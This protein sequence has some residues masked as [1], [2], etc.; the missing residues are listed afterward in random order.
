MSWF[1]DLTPEIT[2]DG[3]DALLKEYDSRHTKL[4]DEYERLYD[5]TVEP[6]IPD[7]LGLKRQQ[8]KRDEWTPIPFLRLAVSKIAT[9][10]Y[11]R[12]VDRTTGDESLDKLLDP[13]WNMMKRF[14]PGVC[15]SG[16]IIGDGAIRMVPSWQTGITLMW[17][18]GRHIVPIYD[19]IT[20]EIVGMIYDYIYD[21]VGSQITR[22]LG[23][24]GKTKAI[25]EIV[26]R[27]VRDQITGEILQPGI[28]A[29]FD[30]DVRIPWDEGMDPEIDRLNPMGDYLDCVFWKNDD[31]LGSVRG[32][33]DAKSLRPLLNGINEIIVQMKLVVKYSAYPIITTDAD[34][35]GNPQVFAGKV[36]ALGET[37]SGNPATAQYLEWSQKMDGSLKLLDRLIGLLHET[38]QVPAVAVGDLEHI[39][40]LSSG[41][42]YEVA[43]SPVLDL[44]SMRQQVYTFQELE[45]MGLCVAGLA[46]VG[47]A[48][49]LTKAQFGIDNMPDFERIEE[50]LAEAS[51]EFAPVNVARDEEADARTHSTRISAGFESEEQAIRATHPD[52]SDD[53]VLEELKR[54]GSDASAMVDTATAARGQALR[55]RLTQE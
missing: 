53:R 37:A 30:G 43:M 15:K 55:D 46:L 48:P 9:L 45:L 18:D 36:W 5:A 11:G 12:E 39:G 4:M 33:S 35:E 40:E 41:R 28:R 16:G 31:S 51:V 14:M 17:W 34:I 13:I 21:P 22:G 25:R 38:S 1:D 2:S 42:A 27:H 50:T 10:M 26:T 49:N 47:M 6:T 8:E 23:G 44:V 20:L 19:P 7:T 32:A 54:A 29:R 52:W 3:L 24:K